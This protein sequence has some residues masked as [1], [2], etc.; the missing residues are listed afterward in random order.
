M[1]L[2]CLS[3]PKQNQGPE[4]F[5]ICSVLSF[6]VNLKKKNIMNEKNTS[7]VSDHH[8]GLS[9]HHISK[10]AVRAST[11]H[12]ALF[13]HVNPLKSIEG[14]I[15]RT[16]VIIVMNSPHTIFKEQK[17]KWKKYVCDTARMIILQNKYFWQI[18]MFNSFVFAQEYSINVMPVTWFCPLD[19]C[20]NSAKVSE[21]LCFF[22]A[23]RGNKSVSSAEWF[24][25]AAFGIFL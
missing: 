12:L 18:N 11:G 19:F 9:P 20:L 1:G 16:L 7:K 25:K 6:F 17:D 10:I 13:A 4:R 23:I 2:A 15:Q 3:P 5:C 8:A 22:A 14:S 24:W 21:L